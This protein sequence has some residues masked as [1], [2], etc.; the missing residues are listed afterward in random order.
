MNIDKHEFIDMLGTSPIKLSQSVRTEVQSCFPIPSDFT[1]KWADINR[2]INPSGV[3]VTDYGIVTKADSEILKAVNQLKPKK[4]KIR[5]I[6]HIFLWES[7]E[8]DDFS[9]RSRSSGYDL[10]FSDEVIAHL[11]SPKFS[12]VFGHYKHLY[13]SAKTSSEK[14]STV[15]TPPNF[16]SS[17]VERAAVEVSEAASS[18]TAVN[19]PMRYASNSKTGHGFAAEDA[20]AQAERRCGH[21][22]QVVGGDNAKNG[23]DLRVDGVNVQCK[24]HRS[25]YQSI[26]SCFE[27][28]ESGN[29]AFRYFNEDGSPMK[30]EVPK[31]QYPE[32]VNQMRMHILNGEVPG[33]T[34]PKRA[35]EIVREGRYTYSQV[36]NIARAGNIDSLKFDLQ[37]GIVQCTSALGVTFAISFFLY[38]YTSGNKKEAFKAAAL[39]SI[40]VFGISYLNHILTSQLARTSLVRAEPLVRVA[41]ALVK[42][43]GPRGAATVTNAIRSISGGSKIYGAAA[44]K[45]LSKFLR[46]STWLQALIIAGSFFPSIVKVVRGKISKAQFAKTIVSLTTGLVGAIAGGAAGAKGGAV[47]GSAVFPGVGTAVG[48]AIGGVVGGT[49]GAL[50]ISTLTDKI[51]DKIREPDTV[52][53]HRLLNGVFA[54]LCYDYLLIPEEVDEVISYL[55]QIDKKEWKEFFS[56]L[57]WSSRQ[58]QFTYDFLRK[59]FEVVIRHRPKSAEPYTDEAVDFLVELSENAPKLLDN[60]VVCPNSE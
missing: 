13:P 56:E 10:L 50:G 26:R 53:F 17:D 7:F 55:D 39:S 40:R 16:A 29:I 32:A 3:V 52:I 30:I 41:D 31:D 48:G 44:M 60:N 22:A 14:N 27:K 57:A 19:G 28:N 23:P 37:T 6:Y 21:D 47:V 33:V 24:Y 36:R 18:D 4:D 2:Q 46:T 59:N 25:A 1:I 5:D 43:I 38:W 58:Y 9:I 8:P 51:S 15:P 34:D 54:L 42:K 35:G 45:Y 49:V 12:E 20:S 11:T